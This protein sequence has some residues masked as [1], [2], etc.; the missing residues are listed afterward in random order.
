[1]EKYG[2]NKERK[3]QWIKPVSIYEEWEKKFKKNEG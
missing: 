1:M 2:I 3:D